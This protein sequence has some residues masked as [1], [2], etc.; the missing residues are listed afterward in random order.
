M[1]LVALVLLALAATVL[2][3]YPPDAMDFNAILQPP[4]FSHWAGT[5]ELGRDVLSRILH[6][7]R[8][9]L[10]SA[11]V[12][13]AI[14]AAA[15]MILGCLSGVVGGVVDTAIMRIVD[16]AL[17]LPGLVIAMA[18]T[19]ALGPSLF[20]AVIALGLLGI[21]GYTRLAR[22]LA[23]SLREREFVQA[24]R[25]M[26]AGTW[27]IVLRHILPNVAPAMLVYASFHFGGALL[28]SS[29]LSF[30]GLGMQPPH[31]EWG[32]MIGAGRDY[33]LAA[34]WCVTFPGVAVAIGALSANLLGDALRDA[35]DEV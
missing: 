18:L 4:S 16:V 14:G 26:G 6:G 15:G 24:S 29:A 30:I 11:C 5:D 35:I 1:T 25:S 31:A 33:V 28:A 21:P 32:A 23:L 19:A 8:P 2:S 17:A 22:G 3:P 10:L 20:N 9:S 27:F 13:V 12:I 34:W 7:A